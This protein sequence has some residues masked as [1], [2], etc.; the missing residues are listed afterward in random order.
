MVGLSYE[1]IST[2]ITRMYNGKRI[3]IENESSR[4]F[5]FNQSSALE[6]SSLDC[7]T[8]GTLR[9]L[10]SFVLKSLYKPAIINFY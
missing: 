4:L 5:D 6:L 7:P 9:G 8:K 1:T 3:M 2:L 10:M